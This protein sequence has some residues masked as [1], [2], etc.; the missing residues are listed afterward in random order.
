MKDLRIGIDSVAA[1][2][3]PSDGNSTYF[4]HLIKCV[5]DVD[6]RNHYFLYLD[7]PPQFGFLR[8]RKNVTTRV[9]DSSG[10]RGAFNWRLEF[11]REKVGI[12]L[13]LR[14]I[15]VYVRSAHQLHPT[16]IPCKGVF[17]VLDVAFALPEYR[18]HFVARQ[19]EVFTR[20]MD[21]ALRKA[22]RFI[23]ISENTRKDLARI[24][25]V[26]S[27]RIDVVYP[28]VDRSLFHTDYQ[29]S[30][31]DTCL[32]KH[33]LVRP[34]I[35]YVGALQPRKNLIRLLQAFHL[36][37][38]GGVGDYRLVMVGPESWLFDPIF[39][40]VH[41]LGIEQQV[42]FTG[43][44]PREDLPLIL[45]GAAV[46]AFP[47]LYEGF[48]IPLIE[49]MACGTPVVGSNTSSI[50]EVTDSAACL[51]DP[52]D[53]KAM[54]DTLA[55]VLTDSGV[56][57]SLIAAGLERSKLFSWEESARRALKVFHKVAGIAQ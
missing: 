5:L 6:S 2:R 26:P 14:R 1:N 24:Y 21:V 57:A 23:T 55:R 31:I 22:H 30:L 42:T 35:L 43:L 17:V 27:R 37:R 45:S 29:S 13:F 9:L 56:R 19:R 25:G 4:H 48:G 16:L 53:P 10:R 11:D 18:S 36:L 44:V 50:P 39:R 33:R 12:D 41:R 15:D 54:A 8:S 34:Y 7:Q 38:E 40:E 32:L 49:A 46:L 52:H 28:G 3:V 20:G 51:F 47:A